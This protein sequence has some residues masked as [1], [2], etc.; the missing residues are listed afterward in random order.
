ML[1]GFQMA[2]RIYH[3][4][5]IVISI[6]Q[7]LQRYFLIVFLTPGNKSRNSI[8]RQVPSMKC[9][10]DVCGAPYIVLGQFSYPI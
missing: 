8:A 1:E 4:R 5:L 10:A 9:L 2:A 7:Y 3:R 6:E